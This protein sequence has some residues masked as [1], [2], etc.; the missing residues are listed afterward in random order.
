MNVNKKI[1]RVLIVVSALFLALLTY[2]LYFNMFEAEK[3]STHPYNRR[4]WDG[5]KYVTR[6][7][8]Y[9]RN[10]LILAET[11][12]DGDSIHRVYSQGRLYSHVIGYCSQVY[13]KSLIEREFDREL[14]GKDD[15]DLFNGDKK[16]GFDLNLTIDNS[17]QSYAYDRMQG[18]RGALV[19]MNPKTGEIIAMVSLPDFDPD[20][21]TLEGQWNAIVEQEDAPLIPRAVQGLYPPGST[22]KIV[23]AALA[24][25]N[26][27][28]D[29]IFEDTG[30]FEAGS[31]K[32]E[33]Y[34]NKKHGEISLDR[35][36]DV[37]SNQVFCTV[38]YELGGEKINEISK[39]FGI[40]SAL[41][42]DIPVKDSRIE[43]EQIAKEDAA[44]IGIG[45]GQ[46]LTTPLQMA[47]ICS[48]VANDGYMVKPYIVDS[49]SKEGT[50]IS[51]TQQK[52][53]AQPIS[54]ECAEYIQ[55]LMIGAVQNGTGSRAQI[56]GVTVAGKTGTAEN[57]T[58]KDHAW[59]VG[60]APA[61]D[62]QI[63]IAVV[64]ENDGTSGGDAAAPIA[65]NVMKEYLAKQVK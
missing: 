41:D 42:F 33:N 53:I 60:Y 16:K 65:G 47:M 27:M 34:N 61:E 28:K 56:N 14:I 58:D 37:S 31:F 50:V 55:Q 35:A 22:Y 38:G 21:A 4:Q 40:N 57:G 59:F 29:R 46:L 51:Q 63:A 62:P 5:E 18:R 25:E 10:G 17:V 39:R 1:I 54:K 3:L 13:G 44:L 9:D 43:Y 19:A 11:V 48:A 23:T 52:I 8:I 36:F 26:G 30:A 32:V 2:L 20:S 7:K 12:K 49:V 24:Y 6:G 15:I 45:Q 64:L